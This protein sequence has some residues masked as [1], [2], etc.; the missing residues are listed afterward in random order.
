MLW[1]IV[2]AGADSTPTRRD[3]PAGNWFNLEGGMI[4]SRTERRR[5]FSGAI[6]GLLLVP[7]LY[8]CAG[9]EK[10]HG[11]AEETTPQPPY[12]DIASVPPDRPEKTMTDE[13]RA[14]AEAELRELATARQRAVERK[15]STG[16]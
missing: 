7:A 2:D 16:Q 11:I 6:F 9:L 8:G 1:K 3:G 13:E 5:R 10:T 14:R 12:P 4:Q 15:L